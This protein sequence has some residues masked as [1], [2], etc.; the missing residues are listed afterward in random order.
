MKEYKVTYTFG[1]TLIINAENEQDAE[2]QV[3]NKTNDELLSFAKVWTKD[4][5]EIQSVEEN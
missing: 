4:G 5:F 1:A 2:N 3:E